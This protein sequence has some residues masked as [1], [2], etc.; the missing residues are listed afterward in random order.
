MYPKVA[1][2]EDM[3]IIRNDDDKPPENEVCHADMTYREVP[4]FASV[5]HGVHIPPFG[6][7]TLWDDMVAFAEGLLAPMRQF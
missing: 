3:I 7:D 5:L 4:I 1:G 2:N 6:G